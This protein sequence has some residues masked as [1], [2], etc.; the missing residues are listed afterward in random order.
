MN[1]KPD[2][3]LDEWVRQSLNRL[4]NTP[5]PGTQF[6]AERLWTK[7]RPELQKKPYSRQ[8]GWVWWAA[9]ACLVSA[10]LG[11]LSLNQPKRERNHPITYVKHRNVPVAINREPKS[12]TENDR[13]KEVPMRPNYSSRP[14]SKQMPKRI[15]PVPTPVLS[16]ET[17]GP[18]VAHINE[19]PMGAR[20]DSIRSIAPEKTKEKVASAP[21][22]RFQVVHLNELQ[23][24]EEIRP[25]TY[26]TEGF[27]RL[28]LGN[29]G[30]HMPETAHPSIMLPI[31]SKPIQ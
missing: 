30:V 5:P 1:G 31:T 25:T 3:H 15:A 13:L 9:A 18:W 8:W 24:E 2:E 17:A 12:L 10:V 22:R 7:M 29:T 6:D 19:P 20:A 16:S 14:A 23:A 4:P 11:W 27:V 28:G 21:K 26:R